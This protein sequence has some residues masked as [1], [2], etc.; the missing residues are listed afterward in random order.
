MRP[1]TA[2]WAR[3][4]SRDR[5]VIFAVVQAS[6][7]DPLARLSE[8]YGVPRDFTAVTT[9]ILKGIRGEAAL[10]DLRFDSSK[11]PPVEWPAGWRSM[12]TM[13]RSKVPAGSS[14]DEFI[15]EV[16]HEVTSVLAAHASR[17]ERPERP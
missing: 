4:D 15:D 17:Q 7:R 2:R 13:V 10:D 16:I 3:P 12:T 5:A 9:A 6:D 8:A 14:P 1:G 11:V